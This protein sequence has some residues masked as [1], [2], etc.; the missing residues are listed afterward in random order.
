M[1]HLLHLDS[2]IGPASGPG[3]SRS[4]EI[5][6]TFAG[7]WREAGAQHTVHHR[8]LVAEPLPHLLDPALH[9]APP[10]RPAGS[11][12][13]PAAEALQARL[14]E[15]LL[16]ADVLLVGCPL[17]N[18]SLPSTLKVWLDNVH[19]PGTTTAFPGHDTQPLAGRTAVVVTSRGGTYDPG[20]PTADWDHAVPPLRIVLG[21]ALGMDVRVITTS[22]TLSEEVEALAAGAERAR[23]ERA[24]AHE[25]AAALARELAGASL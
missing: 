3:A 2:S 17:Y 12:P 22:A 13:D 7:A 16:A 8:D 4:R 24:A 5:T 21:D 25:Q 9:W 20:T 11:S 19:V 1:P 10:L 6:A 14:L 18:Y 15:E 23:A